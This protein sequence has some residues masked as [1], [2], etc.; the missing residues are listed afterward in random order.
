VEK[1]VRAHLRSGIIFYAKV[2]TTIVGTI[3]GVIIRNGF[4]G[5][6]NAYEK[7]MYIDEK[8]RGKMISS[9]FE[10]LFRKFAQMNG[11]DSVIFT[12]SLYSGEDVMKASRV[13]V[14]RGYIVHGIQMRRD[15]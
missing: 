5:E 3:M 13:F 2:G 11:C 9:K 4:T 12:P 14:K 15:L 6:K 1:E 7:W 8:H 10:R